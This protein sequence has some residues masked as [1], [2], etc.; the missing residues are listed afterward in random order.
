MSLIY[1][2]SDDEDNDWEDDDEDLDED[3]EEVDSE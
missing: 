3:N 1:K 2:F